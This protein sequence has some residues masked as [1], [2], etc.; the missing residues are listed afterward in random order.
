MAAN[1]EALRVYGGTTMADP[2][3]LGRLPSARTP[4]LVVWGA[5]DRIVPPEHG[6]AYAAALPGARFALIEDAGHL[7]QLE[8]PET[9]LGLVTRFAAVENAQGTT[10]L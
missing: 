6:R 10:P 4:V 7:P 2:T 8:T 3:L 9:L 5:A 1:R